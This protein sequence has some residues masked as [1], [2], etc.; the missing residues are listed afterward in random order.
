MGSFGNE[1]K[2]N[3]ISGSFGKFHVILQIGGA[4]IFGAHSRHL[5]TGT[6][7]GLQSLPTVAS[8]K[9]DCQSELVIKLV[10][11]PGGIEVIVLVFLAKSK[12]VGILELSGSSPVVSGRGS[13]IRL[14]E[15]EE[16]CSTNVLEVVPES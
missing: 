9:F 12:V 16:A 7:V 14:E 6:S 10:E 4:L 5:T 8:Q 1:G 13:G 11:K 15:D 2:L 3:L